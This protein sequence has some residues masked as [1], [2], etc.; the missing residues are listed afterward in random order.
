MK[1]IIRRIGIFI[2]TVAVASIIVFLLLSALPGDAAATK[3]GTEASP[4]AVAHLRHDMGLDRPLYMRY[5]SWAAGMLRGNMGISQSSGV[6]ISS[7]IFQGLQVTF[8]LVLIAMLIALIIAFIFGTL[9]A[10]L[11]DRPSGM[12]LSVISQIGVSIP[13]FLA[14]LLLVIVF[15][16][17]LGWLPATGW[18]APDDPVQFLRHVALPAFSLGLVQGAILSRYVRSAVLEVT[19]EDFM[20]TAQ[21]KGLSFGQAL[22]KHGIRNALVPIMNIVGVETASIL[23]G[24]VV[25]ER[26]F[27]IRGLGS[28]LVSSVENRDL[29][30]VQAIVMVLVIM[31]LFVNL[32]V[33]LLSAIVDPRFGGER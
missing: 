26:V 33:D 32:I 14:G 18:A 19:T 9:A 24:A 8:L 30:E 31:V 29:P 3:L 5:A 25:V 11:R 27:E 1:K 16:V 23:I 12:V 4:E 28:L 15:S 7:D 13:A 10:V 20:R 6:S 2:I 21:A 22:R 17:A